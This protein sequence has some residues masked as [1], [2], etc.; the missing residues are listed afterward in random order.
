[1]RATIADALLAASRRVQFR[2]KATLLHRLGLGVTSPD[3]VPAGVDTIDC[4]D[5]VRIRSSRPSDIMFRELYVHGL[6][7]DDVL[8]ALE[9]LLR[10]GDV[11]WD[12]GANYGF[13]SV[14]VHRR[15]GG[16]V[17]ITAFEPNPIVLR[18]L[19]VNLELNGAS[20]VRVEEICLSDAEG[21]VRFFTSEDHSWNA[22][23]IAEFAA[24][25]G[26]GI[27]VR[28]QATTIDRY[29]EAHPAPAAIKLDVEGAEHLVV[30]GGRRFLASARTSLVA[31]YNIASIQAAGL[32]G[33]GYLDLFRELGFRIELLRRP[34]VG[35]YRW[36]DR[37]AVRSAA[38][39]PPLCNLVLTK[40]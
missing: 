30:A 5:G 29:V 36:S 38:V 32:T 6:Y 21:E 7:Q 13:M 14:W 4:I 1:M 34:W 28:A 39:L 17:R 27:E 31:E 15:F 22:T 2:G 3:L 20:D 16:R 12:V 11:F 8:V 10:P 40:P 9:H 18:D 37:I 23:L 35:R 33:E 24:A 19:R 26:E 25:Q